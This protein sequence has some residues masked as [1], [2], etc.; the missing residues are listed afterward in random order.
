[1]ADNLTEI[2]NEAI[3]EE[4]DNCSISILNGQC[5]DFAEYKYRVGV[6]K[7]LNETKRIME[8]EVAKIAKL[9]DID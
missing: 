4:I 6:I 8:D 9:Q 1:M 2:Y 7:G 3:D 5:K